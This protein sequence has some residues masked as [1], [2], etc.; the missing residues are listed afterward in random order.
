MPFH[1]RLLPIIAGGVGTFLGGPAL[2]LVAG[3]ATQAILG[4]GGEAQITPT[5]QALPV[6]GTVFVAPDDLRW[7]TEGFAGSDPSQRA[8][9]EKLRQTEFIAVENIVESHNR[10]GKVEFLISGRRLLLEILSGM[11]KE[12]LP[13]MVTPAPSF[14]AQAAVIGG[15][16]PVAFTQ[17]GALPIT[18]AVLPAV[19]MIAGAIGMTAGRAGLVAAFG[20][21]MRTLGIATGIR[22]IVTWFTRNPGTAAGLA[23]TAGLTADQ[24]F[25]AVTQESLAKNVILTK[26]D[27]KGFNRTVRV[28]KRLAKFTRTRTRTRK[29]PMIPTCPAKISC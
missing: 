11:K 2:G 3:G 28:G 15:A 1:K 29:V 21:I 24:F 18:P 22:A 19:P 5:R 6:A 16:L 8:L 13:T 20:G 17:P 26:G 9:A 25:D 27:L 10:V 4:N 23:L 14:A 7:T 12:G